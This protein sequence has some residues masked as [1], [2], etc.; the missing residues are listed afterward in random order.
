MFNYKT[1]DSKTFLR[2][3]H[4]LYVDYKVYLILKGITSSVNF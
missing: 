2:N 3:E 4:Y 1:N